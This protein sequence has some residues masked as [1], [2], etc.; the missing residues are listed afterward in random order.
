M[1][2]YDYA[3][4]AA[5]TRAEE[6]RSMDDGEPRGL[7]DGYCADDDS[8]VAVTFEDWRESYHA[9]RWD[10]V[11]MHAKNECDDEMADM[12]CLEI[13]DLTA[14]ILIDRVML[15]RKKIDEKIREEYESFLSEHGLE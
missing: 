7:P 10:D 15:M 8:P 13:K 11:M 4:T 5:H 6:E 14:V 2:D 1:S 3:G 9:D 12:L